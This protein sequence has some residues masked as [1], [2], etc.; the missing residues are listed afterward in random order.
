ML[1]IQKKLYRTEGIRVSDEDLKETNPFLEGRITKLTLI[2]IPQ[3]MS[4]MHKKQFVNQNKF[5][6]HDVLQKKLNILLLKYGISIQELEKRNPEVVSD[7][8]IG[9]RLIMG[10][11]PKVRKV[12]K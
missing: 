9:Y 10:T 8:P 3:K 11:A 6:Y 1:L 5:I 12:E 7:L 4:K 2:T